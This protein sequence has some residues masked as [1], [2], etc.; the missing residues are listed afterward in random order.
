MRRWWALIAIAAV[1][2]PVTIDTPYRAHR[3]DPAIYSDAVGF[4]AWTRAFVKWEFGFCYL[5]R[6]KEEVRPYKDRC[7]NKYPPGLALMRLPVMAWLVDRDAPDG[8]ISS[9]E[10]EA[11]LWLGA[12]ALLV[13]CGFMLATCLRLGV[14]P[15]AANVVV[16]AACFGTG[17][18]HYGTYDAS[19]AHVFSAALVAALVWLGVVGPPRGRGIAWAVAVASVA[20]LIPMTRLPDALIVV[21]LAAGWLGWRVLPLKGRERFRMAV[22]GG[23]PVALGLVGAAAVQLAYNRWS[24]GQWTLSSY[25]PDESLDFS[26]LN[27]GPVLLSYQKGLFTWYPALL[28]LLAAALARRSARGWGIVA[29]AA[30][31]ALTVL[32]GSWWGWDLGWGFGHRGFVEVVPV[33]AVAGAVALKG[34]RPRIAVPTF[35]VL[36]V[37]TLATVQLLVGWWEETLDHAHTNG[38]QYWSHLVGRESL[39]R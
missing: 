35:A 31:G 27:E 29:A 14:P 11:S 16:L 8:T 17:L 18:F 24:S 10:H 33:V 2:I 7:T 32:Y 6:D 15:P 36:A 13:A 28:V 19:A 4:H 38:E 5:P 21:A 34:L 9:G 20:F 26:R 23:L 25:T 22:R 1:V 3:G 37:C 12:A 39:L 30:V